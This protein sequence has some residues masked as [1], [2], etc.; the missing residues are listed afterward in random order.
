MTGADAI[1][2]CLISE[3]VGLVFG[4]PGAAVCPL[5]DKLK[6]SKIRTVAVRHEQNAGHAASGYARM[7]G[8]PGVCIATSGPGAT[9]LITGIATAYMDSVPLVAITGQVESGLLGRD[10]FQEIDITGACAPFTKHSYIVSTAAD[11][12]QIFREAF[13]IAG[14][15]RPGPVLIDVPIDISLQETS[16]FTYPEAVNI[17][18]YRPTSKGHAVQIKRALAAISECE[19]PVI[20]AGGGVISADAR[21]ELIQFSRQN[22]IPVVTTM[23]GIGVMPSENGLFF[24]MLGSHG[25][26]AANRAIENADL[27]IL[28]GARV[29]DRALSRPGR[30]AERAKIIHIDIDPAEIGKNMNAHIPIVGDVGNVLSA[31]N[32]TPVSRDFSAW[33]DELR[34]FSGTDEAPNSNYVNPRRFMRILSKHTGSDS[35]LTVDVGQNQIWAA[36]NF[37]IRDNRF[38]TSGGLG[39]MGYA[40]PAAVGAKLYNPGVTVTAVAGDGGFQMSMPELATINEQKLD[41]KIVIMNNNRLGMIREL[42]DDFYGGSHMMISQEG[43]PDFQA[44]AGAYGIP[45]RRVLSDGDT[46][47]AV[48]DMIL[49]DGTFILECMIDPDEPSKG[50][51]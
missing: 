22:D 3:D 47:R 48:N 49:H 12:P 25:A 39:T 24:G 2:K 29:G 9:N 45:C 38:L 7:S 15:G 37:I 17:E 44:I 19:R 11:I 14:T 16:D 5:L 51:V 33:V 30:F 27:L 23:M 1:V 13:H 46:E 6:E 34:K 8:R 10:G 40:I 20:C 36:N 21:D 26:G 18:G 28:C 42:Q 32:K 43:S 4:Y 41:I 50:Q 35:I 31:F